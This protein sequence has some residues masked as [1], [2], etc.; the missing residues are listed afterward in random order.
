MK[1][2]YITLATLIT[3]ALA[4]PRAPQVPR[5]EVVNVLSKRVCTPPS[6]C[7]HITG[8]A[9]CCADAVR[10]NGATCHLHLHD[11]EADD[12]TYDGVPNAGIEW[13]CDNDHNDDDE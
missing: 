10:P 12:C 1:G 3:V 8:C 6:N 2:I 13:H 9:Y 7:E 4:A 5:T 11:G